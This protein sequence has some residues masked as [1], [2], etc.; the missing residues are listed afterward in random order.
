[1]TPSDTPCSS[2]FQHDEAPTT[3]EETVP[4]A[5][6]RPLK[7]SEPGRNFGGPEHPKW[8]QLGA[9]EGWPPQAF[10]M[11]LQTESN[12]GV[13]PVATGNLAP[14]RVSTR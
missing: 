11:N 6:S 13:D 8:R 2:W 9:R 5:R 12:Q 14:L 10:Y 4:G 3:V 7:R 1:M